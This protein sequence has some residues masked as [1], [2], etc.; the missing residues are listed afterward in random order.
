MSSLVLSPK[1]PDPQQQIRSLQQALYDRNRQ[2]ND[3]EARLR[4]SEMR[5]KAV[6]AGV[7]ELR[8]TLA[9][10]YNALRQVFGEIDEM[11]IG[12]TSASSSPVWDSWK[13]K[14][15][16]KSAEAIDVLMMHGTLNAEQLRFHLRVA[17]RTVYN[18][19]GLLNKAGIIHK[20]GGKI[21]LKD[22]K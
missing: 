5:C 17:N 18:I 2:L 14:L 12:E 8:A 13:Q 19:I 1:I 16:G 21:S 15:G 7:L 3:V 20:D 22:L 10:L 4:E 9:P 6:E 11:N